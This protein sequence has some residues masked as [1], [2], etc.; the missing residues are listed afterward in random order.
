MN[1]IKSFFDFSTELN[2]IEFTKHW[3]ERTS[4]PSEKES[5]ESRIVERD[6]NHLYGWRISG[7]M[8]EE[9]NLLEEISMKS[10]TLSK[11]EIISLISSAMRNLS[12]SKRLERWMPVGD[13]FS[14]ILKLGRIFLWD[15]KEKKYLLFSPGKGPIKEGTDHKPGDVLYGICKDFSI[16]VTVLFF[17]GKDKLSQE[18]LEEIARMSG[19]GRSFFVNYSLQEPYGN[20]FEVGIDLTSPTYSRAESLIKSQVI[21]ET[22]SFEPS[23]SEVVVR[24]PFYLSPDF[25]RIQLSKGVVFTKFSPNGTKM[26]YEILDEPKNG[27]DLYSIWQSDKAEDGN[28]LKKSTVIVPAEEVVERVTT[29]GGVKMIKTGK[30]KNVELV[31]GETLMINRIPKGTQMDPSIPYIFKWVTSEP[32]ILKKG[33]VQIALDL[34]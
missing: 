25:K 12:R 3:K 26:S 6:P 4:L 8:D 10:P 29:Y 2:E 14:N 18:D 19:L 23:N 9:G 5:V 20:K 27:M 28:S 33:S 30:R 22:V 7:M 34:I 1:R 17:E 11:A 21:G 24:D 15:G 32:S 16:G 31:P 13:K